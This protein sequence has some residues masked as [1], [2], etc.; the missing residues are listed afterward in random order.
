MSEKI[1]QVEQIPWYGDR[2]PGKNTQ[3]EQFLLFSLSEKSN[4]FVLS[5][6]NL[7]VNQKNLF[8]RK[9]NLKSAKL[10]L[11]GGQKQWNDNMHDS[12]HQQV[13]LVIRSF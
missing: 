3:V 12:I 1:N 7:I 2:L 11:C 9:R 5:N 13:H 8:E 6:L 4:L 10:L